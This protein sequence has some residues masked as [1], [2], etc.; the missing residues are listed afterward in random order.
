MDDEYKQK[1]KVP[2]LYRILGLTKDVCK[3][4]NCSEI[5]KKAYKK[6]ARHCHPD[7]NPGVKDAEEIF[8]LLNSAYEILNNEKDRNE[9]NHKLLL[10]KQSSSDFNKLKEKSRALMESIGEI[11]PPT[12][13]QKISFQQRVQHPR[14]DPI[15]QLEAKKKMEHIVKERTMQDVEL[16]PE[17]LFNE[18]A[19]DPRKFN[20]AFDIVHK[21]DDESIVPHTGIPEAWNNYSC[22][23]G[24]INSLEN[25]YASDCQVTEPKP[26]KKITKEDIKDI[27]VAD[28]YDK[29]ASLDDEY[30][31][32]IRTKLMDRQN[33][34]NKFEKMNYSDFKR[35]D[36]AGY[37]I[38]DRMGIEFGNVLSLNDDEDIMKKFEKIKKKRNGS[39]D[40][41]N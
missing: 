30:Y 22:A 24:N 10:I 8:R 25:M 34:T 1:N 17:M 41:I 6:R 15:S 37:G 13:Q 12:E 7:K 36:T 29:H 11:K 4:P 14:V 27:N 35:D 16:K 26:I 2:D 9:Y 18:G 40:N 39:L 3:E 32:D 23:Y 19:F 20:A 33:D 38:H 5:I 21:K 31:R 28:Y